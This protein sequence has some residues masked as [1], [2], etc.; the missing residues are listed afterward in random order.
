[1]GLLGEYT[2][3]QDMFDG[4]GAGQSGPTFEGGPLSDALNALGV[5]PHGYRRRE[6]LADRGSANPARRA[7]VG[8]SPAPLRPVT[9]SYPN[10]APPMAPVGVNPVSPYDELARFGLLA[11]EANVAYQPEPLVPPVS[12]EYVGAVP[13]AYTDPTIDK[14]LTFRRPDMSM[15]RAGDP[16]YGSVY[17]H[18]LAQGLTPSE[19]NAVMLYSGRPVPGAR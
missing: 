17:G 12:A 15:G 11:P 5:R 3:F 9:P 7:P 18:L 19:A 16:L 2:G 13:P 14:K 1:M 10:Y 4:G 8:A 6:A